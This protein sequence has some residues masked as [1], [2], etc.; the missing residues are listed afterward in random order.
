MTHTPHPQLENHK[1]FRIKHVGIEHENSLTFNERIIVFFAGLLGNPWT[2]YV[3]CIAALVS[4]PQVLASKNIILIDQW[5]TQTFI[6]L[7]ALAIL[8]AFQTITGK[9]LDAM[10]EEMFQNSRL[11]YRDNEALLQ[12]ADDIHKLTKEIHDVTHPP[13]IP[14]KTYTTRNANATK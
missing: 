7:V 3:F 2:F 9:K 14:K 4:L 12:I 11:I 8:Q 13:F 10:I 6:Q 5:V 1:N